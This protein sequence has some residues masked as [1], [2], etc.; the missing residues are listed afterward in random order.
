M[1]EY[2]LPSGAVPKYVLEVLWND[3]FSDDTNCEP[4]DTLHHWLT[5]TIGWALAIT[6]E[7]VSVAQCWQEQ[8]RRFRHILSIPTRMIERVQVWG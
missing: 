2:L 3:A 1:I 4:A 6:P 7:R 5:C 8:P